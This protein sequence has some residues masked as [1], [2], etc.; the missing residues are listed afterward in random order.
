[1]HRAPPAAP[2]A[3]RAAS[4]EVDEP[5]IDVGQYRQQA[6]RRLMLNHLHDAG[7]SLPGLARVDWT[8]LD[9]SGL[10]AAVAG[11]MRVHTALQARQA[12]EGPGSLSAQELHISQQLSASVGIPAQFGGEPMKPGVGLSH[13]LLSALPT[14]KC[15]ADVLAS[16]SDRPTCVICHEDFALGDTL[17]RLPHCD[18]V[19]HAGCIGHWL[20][21]KAACPLCNKDV[22]PKKKS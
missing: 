19:Y 3:R 11:V 6:Q 1:M 9:N 20:R 15:D 5:L 2:P 8:Q 14:C 16:L 18:H 22:Q 13:E 12:R 7:A 10:H 17:R 21:I 4:P